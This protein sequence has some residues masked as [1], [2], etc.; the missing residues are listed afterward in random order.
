MPP[1]PFIIPTILVDGQA[2][3]L[4]IPIL[5]IDVVREVN[6][7]P[8]AHLVLGAPG[9]AEERTRLLGGGQFKPGSEV[10]IKLRQDNVEHVMFTGLVAGIGIRADGS[11]P[12]LS[13]DLRD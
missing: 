10:R 9:N 5:S 4:K 1:S 7:I 13:V 3:D 2:L 12:T 8:R 11:L 6:R